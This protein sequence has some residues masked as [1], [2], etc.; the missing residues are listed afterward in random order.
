MRNPTPFD[1]VIVEAR[2]RCSGDL[3]ERA[4]IEDEAK[5]V[6]RDVQEAVASNRISLT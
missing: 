3:D 1:A 2:H 4:R 5:Q 6:P